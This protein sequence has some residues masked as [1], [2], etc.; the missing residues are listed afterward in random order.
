MADKFDVFAQVKADLDGRN[1]LG[2]LTYGGE[3]DPHDKRDWLINAYQEAL[4]LC[5]YLK[6]GI[7]KFDESQ[8]TKE[9]VK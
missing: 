2:R 3:L 8:P 9:G 5:I 7:I 6:A 4:D 1:A